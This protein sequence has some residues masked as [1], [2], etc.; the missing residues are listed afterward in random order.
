MWKAM[1]KLVVSNFTSTD[2]RVLQGWREMGDAN[3]GQVSQTP[4][5]GVPEL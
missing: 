1:A 5:S 3:A 4:V 2:R